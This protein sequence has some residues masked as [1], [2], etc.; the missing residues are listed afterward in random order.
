MPAERVETLVIGGGQAGLA[1]SHHLKQRKLSHLV[2]E[3]GRI[4]ERWRSERWDGLK[5]QFPNWSVRLPDFPFRHDDPDGFADLSA[6]VDFI[7]AYAALVAPP[8]RCGV[9]VTRLSQDGAGFV[10]ETSDGTIAATNVVIATGPYQRPIGTSPFA[11]TGLFQIHASH[12]RNPAQLPDGAVLV[13]GAGASGA[14]IAEELHRAGRRVFLS[15]GRHNRLPRRYRGRDL[16]CWLADMRLDQTPVEQRGEMKLLPV[17]SGAYGGHTVDFRRFAADGITLLGRVAHVA[18]HVADIAPDL[19]DNLA[20]GDLGYATFCDM[21]DNFVRRRGLS[22]PEDSVTRAQLPDPAAV[23]HPL[24]RL[25]LRA[26]TINA[27]ILATG[28]RLDFGWID[29][30]VFDGNG[31]PLHRH[32]ISHVPGLYFLGLQWMSRMASSFM[33]GVGDD[34]AVLADAIAARP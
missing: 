9:E 4:G 1:M 7:D 25:D 29:L 6:I 19:A 8:I 31:D 33:S 14:Q 16:I 11:D 28:Y 17:I 12:Y 26:E 30:P 2:L 23:T 20:R 27:V 15:V 13:V 10:A 34:A 22:L 5:F 32:G 3:R 21:V 18:G 24:R